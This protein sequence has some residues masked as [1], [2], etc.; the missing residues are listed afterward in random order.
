M[1]SATPLK[2]DDFPIEVE[3]QKLKTQ[4]GE[5]VAA[6]ET[7]ELADQLARRLNCHAE[8]EEQDRWSA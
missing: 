6:A 2:P 3:Q 1:D 5:T 8:Q 4:K 7:K